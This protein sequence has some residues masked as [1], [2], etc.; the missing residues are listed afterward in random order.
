[1]DNI[2]NTIYSRKHTHIEKKK[3]KKKKKAK[4]LRTWVLPTKPIYYYKNENHTH[5]HTYINTYRAGLRRSNWDTF[6]SDQVPS[7]LVPRSVEL[8]AGPN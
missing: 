3:K 2:K 4:T 7:Q 6:R 8:V 5:I 1:M